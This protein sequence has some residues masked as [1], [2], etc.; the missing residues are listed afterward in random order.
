MPKDL[1]MF[2]R[3]LFAYASEVSFMGT[4]FPR[5]AGFKLVILFLQ[6]ITWARHE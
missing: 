3:K 5:S 6:F 2:I 4:Y 1:A